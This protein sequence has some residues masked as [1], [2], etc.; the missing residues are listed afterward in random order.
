MTIIAN[1]GGN[2]KW[3]RSEMHTIFNLTLKK[4]QSQLQQTTNFKRHLS[5]FS[6]KI[7]KIFYENC[8][9][10]D[11]SHEISCLIHYF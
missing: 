6:K 3:I 5:L 7:S 9:P 1:D 2:V 4:H 10:A 11:N 8:L